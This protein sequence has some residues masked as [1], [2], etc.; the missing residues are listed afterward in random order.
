METRRLGNSDLDISVLGLGSWAIGGDIGEWGWGSQ[1]EKHSIATI[2]KALDEGINWIDT[3]PA[4]GLGN[5]EVVIGKALKQSSHTP[6]IFTKCGFRWE[7]GGS[8]EL[9]NRLSQQ[10]IVEEIDLSLSRLGVECIDLYQIHRPVPNYELEEAWYCLTEL[11][12][13][14]KVRHIGVSNFEVDQLERVAAI[15][16]VVSNQPGFSLLNRDVESEVLPWCEAH[17]VG[18]IHH[19]TMSNGLL[20]G[21]WSLE[22]RANLDKRDWRNKSHQFASPL[23]EKNL[24]FIEFLRGVALEKQV[25]VAQLSIA[26]TLTNPA[27]T[28]SILGARTPEQLEQLLPAAQV[29]L[30]QDELKHIDKV[31]ANLFHGL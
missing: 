8:G 29:T 13:A 3:A 31:H 11:Q 17:N 18:T 7:E 22:R 24:E 16:P 20:T 28:G 25:T 5:A 12:K 14:G 27:S 26:W 10:S 4:Y 19:S 23:F 9:I 2:H 15:A 6:F 21:S 30:T 1:N